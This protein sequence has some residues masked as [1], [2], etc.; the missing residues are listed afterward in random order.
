MVA[1]IPVYGVGLRP[2]ACWDCG[3]ESRQG[4]GCLSVVSVV[5]CQGEFSAAGRSLVQSVVS[6]VCYQGEFSATGRSLV[7]RSS[8]DEACVRVCV[9]VC[10]SLSLT[11]CDNNPLHLQ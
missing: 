1:P 5:C 4:R 6:V 9:C 8:T 7:Q 11:R 3:F 10:V 2:L